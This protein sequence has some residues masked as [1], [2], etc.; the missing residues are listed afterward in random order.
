MSLRLSRKPSASP[1]KM[2]NARVALTQEEKTPMLRIDPPP[3][4]KLPENFQA[5][6]RAYV[7]RGED[8]GDTILALLTNNLLDAC[9]RLQPEL[10]P[11]IK[12]IVLWLHWEVPSRCWG[13][14]ARVETWMRHAGRSGLDEM[15]QPLKEA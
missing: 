14:S 12:E 11:R 6:V 4:D 8:P 15:G 7:D 13:S 2:F 9:C 10:L 3:Y 1:W 5:P